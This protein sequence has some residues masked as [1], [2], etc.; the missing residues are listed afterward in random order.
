VKKIKIGVF[1]KFY[2]YFF[3]VPGLIIGLGV[4]GFGG[5]L[6]YL[7]LTEYSPEPR[8]AA[9]TKGN[10]TLEPSP[11]EALRILT[12]NLGYGADDASAD[13]F[14]DG[15]KRIRAL[16][17]AEVQENIEGFRDFI[18][19]SG[20]DLVL[21]QEIDT[22]SRRSYYIDE[23]SFISEAWFKSNPSGTSAFAYNFKVPFV[24]IPFP[25]AI[26]Q[27]QSGLLSLSKFA[28]YDNLRISLPVPFK[29]PV[30]IANLKRCLLTQRL[31]VEQ[32][33]LVLVNL[34]LE[35]YSSG[36]GREAQMQ[37]LVDFLTEEYAKGNYCIAGGDFNQTFPNA[38]EKLYAL[39]NT[40][41]FT[42]GKLSQDQLPPGW[43]FVAD[44]SVPSSRLLN[45]PYN[46]DWNTTQLYAIDG[47][48]VS[49]NIEVLSVKTVNAEFR[50]TD[51]NPVL[52]E[53]LLK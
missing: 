22:H 7:T 12:W 53:V 5:L 28:S 18:L 13:F 10:A 24:P 33:E 46:Y 45:E 3:V 43:R 49:P 25:E 27:V 32:R 41:H 11:G 4:L 51:H 50:Y 2:K 42:P 30:R 29:W 16:N 52:L 1:M 40:E 39:K 8:T 36:E 47:F 20:A 9:L 15:G 26:G 31:P 21:L 48:I 19:K 14:M 6:A 37:V 38:D 17:A 34:H 35:A 23:V 44:T